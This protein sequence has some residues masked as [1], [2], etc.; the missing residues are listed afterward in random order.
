MKT[1]IKLII[2][3]QVHNF[4]HF[5]IFAFISSLSTSQTE[6]FFQLMDKIRVLGRYIIRESIVALCILAFIPFDGYFRIKN[7]L[8]LKKIIP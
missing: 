2:L 5:P 8:G 4:T 3:F 1:I 7:M 6:Y